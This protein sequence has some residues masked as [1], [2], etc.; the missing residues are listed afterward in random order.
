[1]QEGISWAFPNP[2]FALL[3]VYF[4]FKLSDKIYRFIISP[5]LNF[6]FIIPLKIIAHVSDP[7]V[8]F[9]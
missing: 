9:S 5:S 1:M 8:R 3:S 2:K 4:L 7:F 6:F